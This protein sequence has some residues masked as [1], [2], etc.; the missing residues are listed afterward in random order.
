[1]ACLPPKTVQL[2][3]EAIGHFDPFDLVRR[4]ESH[5]AYCRERHKFQQQKLRE[6]EAARCLA[7]EKTDVGTSTKPHDVEAISEHCHKNETTRQGSATI[8]G[9]GHD[10]MIAKLALVPQR[11]QSRDSRVQHHQSR[12]SGHHRSSS[13]TSLDRARLVRNPS[14][15]LPPKP[16]QGPQHQA[17]S[18]HA[19]TKQGEGKK[20]PLSRSQ[21]FKEYSEETPLISRASVFA[22][23]VPDQAERDGD[24]N[25]D[26]GTYVPKHAASGLAKTTTVDVDDPGKLLQQLS[27]RRPS[28]TRKSGQSSKRSSR[29]DVEGTPSTPAIGPSWKENPTF[30]NAAR[31]RAGAKLG[32]I[33]EES[34]KNEHQ[35]ALDNGTNQ[36]ARSTEVKAVPHSKDELAEKEQRRRTLR[37]KIS[38]MRLRGRGVHDDAIQLPEHSDVKPTTSK[39]RS[40]LLIF[41]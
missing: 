40:M 37:E 27:H 32:I 25:F 4:L 9:T 36:L 41:R 13:Q 15:A 1:M 29:L 19:R 11:K 3:T 31:T 28:V 35:K 14:H 2:S 34:H 24:P 12:P 16:T 30:D 5:Q 26:N 39:R 10:V 20:V 22:S 17:V 33:D 23:N 7:V 8:G 18:S 21:S 38:S 6:I